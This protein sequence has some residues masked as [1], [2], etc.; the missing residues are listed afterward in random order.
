MGHIFLLHRRSQRIYNKY[1]LIIF[2]SL[3]LALFSGFFS[4]SKVWLLSEHFK[5]LKEEY[6]QTW[7]M[8]QGSNINKSM[9]ARP[10]CT[11]HELAGGNHFVRV[12]FA[13]KKFVSGNLSVNQFVLKPKTQNVKKMYSNCLHYQQFCLRQ[14]YTKQNMLG[15]VL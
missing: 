14:E 2:C 9:G 8:V 5:E 11:E 12:Q 3:L 1:F 10:G 6:H 7:S 13:V 15:N 4:L